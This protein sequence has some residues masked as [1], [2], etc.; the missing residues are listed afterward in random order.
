MES[1]KV[2]TTDNYHPEYQKD[3]KIFENFND[4]PFVMIS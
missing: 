2:I 4:S 1:T 3:S